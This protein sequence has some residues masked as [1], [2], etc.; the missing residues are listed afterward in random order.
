MK[1]IKIYISIFMMLAISG[2]VH[3]VSY[4]DSV[5]YKNLT[6]MKGEMKVFFQSCQKEVAKGEYALSA[7][8]GFVLS[9]AKAYEYEKG[10]GLN[11]DTI[12]Q[13]KTLEKTIVEVK[14][15]Y[16]SNVYSGSTCEARAEGV[17]PDASTGCLTIGY[18]IAKWKILETAFDIAITTEQSKIEEFK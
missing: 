11:D 3:L 1:Y 12:S 6:D 4:Y 13:L 18:C 5:S 10:K 14:S 15:R 8:D 16:S 7:I 2:C 9:S 17:A